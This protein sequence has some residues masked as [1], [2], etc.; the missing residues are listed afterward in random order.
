MFAP[1]DGAIQTSSCTI[2]YSPVDIEVVR[3]FADL[4]S[5]MGF[6]ALMVDCNLFILDAEVNMG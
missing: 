3:W 1:S 6:R 5:S 2:C 4:E